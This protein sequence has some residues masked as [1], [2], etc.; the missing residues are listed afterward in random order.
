MIFM[1]MRTIDIQALRKKV[2]EER[3]VTE[4]NIEEIQPI[5]DNIQNEEKLSAIDLVPYLADRLEEKIKKNNI[6]KISDNDRYIIEEAVTEYGEISAID[7]LTDTKNTEKNIKNENDELITMTLGEFKKIVEE[8]R[9]EVEY[10]CCLDLLAHIDMKTMPKH[11]E[12]FEDLCD[13]VIRKYIW[14]FM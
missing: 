5:K 10:K 2:V 3:N 11:V 12:D 9:F 8:K 14:D 13:F 4:K 1:K 6:E 7:L